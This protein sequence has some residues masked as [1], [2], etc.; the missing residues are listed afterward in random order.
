MNI[1]EKLTDT[2]GIPNINREFDKR[3]FGTFLKHKKESGE[4]EYLYVY[5]KENDTY[6]FKNKKG[7]TFTYN[8]CEN[9]PEFF[10]VALKK[11]FYSNKLNKVFY[12]SLL[13]KRQWKRS[14]YIDNY[15]IK[16]FFNYFIFTDTIINKRACFFSFLENEPILNVDKTI[17]QS[18]IDNNFTLINSDFLL[19]KSICFP[20]G[21]S[22][23]YHKYLIGNFN[24]K[25]TIFWLE[26][27][28]FIQEFIEES[29]KWKFNFQLKHYNDK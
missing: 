17:F 5:D 22:L 6:Y 7:L 19:T 28:P 13:P 9:N 11:G 2:S 10:T 21:F 15:K 27:S 16:N 29:N 18:C 8:I 24:E 23:F 4:I 26:K 20:E 12:V 14:L 25:G 1:W 3:Y